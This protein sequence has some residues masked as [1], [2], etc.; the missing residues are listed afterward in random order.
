MLEHQVTEFRAGKENDVPLSN[1]CEWLGG[2]RLRR[3]PCKCILN[4][5]PELPTRR[6][7]MATAC[8]LFVMLTQCPESGSP[9]LRLP[10][11][12]LSSRAPVKR[13]STQRFIPP[14]AAFSLRLNSVVASESPT[15][16]SHLLES[17]VWSLY[18]SHTSG[19]AGIP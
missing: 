10:G 9:E 11:A 4:N 5:Q 14:A 15:G 19:E 2:A 3:L 17:L 12:Y 13:P 18:M 8:H 16:T 6:E 1:Y 7:R